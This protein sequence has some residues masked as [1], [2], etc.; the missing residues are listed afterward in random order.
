MKNYNT[1]TRCPDILRPLSA[2]IDSVEF[3]EWMMAIEE[4]TTRK[5]AFNYSM[6]ADELSGNSN[7]MANMLLRIQAGNFE[8]ETDEDEN[9]KK[10]S[11]LMI[12]ITE[13]AIKETLAARQQDNKSMREYSTLLGVSQGTMTD[14]ED[15]A[16]YLASGEHAENLLK[17]KCENAGTE[18]IETDVEETLRVKVLGQRKNSGLPEIVWSYV[19]E[20][21][22][23]KGT[24]MA[25]EIHKE[26]PRY[27]VPTI[28]V[29]ISQCK[30]SNGKS[31]KSY[32]AKAREI[33]VPGMLVGEFTEKLSDSKVNPRTVRRLWKE[34]NN[35]K[36]TIGGN[37]K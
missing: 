26:H 14:E 18:Y 5:W 23:Q 29:V 27:S 20:K 2:N 9:K 16:D 35:E 11:K 31:K 33:F 21:G 17:E 22:W 13:N 24:L 37:T 8:F 28:K 19:S 25:A 34:L 30:N 1:K 12:L 32:K 10:L 15:R 6:D 7:A 36:N 3:C 4:V